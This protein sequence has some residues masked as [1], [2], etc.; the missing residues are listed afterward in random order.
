M[1]REFSRI[2]RLSRSLDENYREEQNED[3]YPKVPQKAC[4]TS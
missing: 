2:D 4:D 3:A 1:Q